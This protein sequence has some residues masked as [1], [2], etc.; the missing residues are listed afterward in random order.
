MSQTENNM[1][2]RGTKQDDGKRKRKIEIE[3]LGDGNRVFYYIF[4]ISMYKIE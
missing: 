2:K 4:T 1:K 3:G